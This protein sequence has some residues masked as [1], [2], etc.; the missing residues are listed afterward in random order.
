[1][2]H[3]KSPTPL[4]AEAR[5]RSAFTLVELLVVIAAIGVL[6]VLTTLGAR[7]LTQGTRLA[8]ATNQVVNA[9]GNARAAAIRDGVVTGLMFRPAWFPATPQI[10]QRV[11]IVTIRSTG[12]REFFESPIP[13]GPAF[14]EAF[15]PVPE[16]PI[17]PLP[18]GIKVAGPMFDPPGNIG[19]VAA[20]LVW[21]TQMEA[22]LAASCAEVTNFNRTV[23]VLFA[24]DGQFLTRPPKSSA[25]ESKSF[26]DWY[27]NG[28]QDVNQ[29]PSPPPQTPLLLGVC[30]SGNFEWF[31]LQDGL[32]DECNL[33]FV[34]YL[35]VYDDRA[36]REAKTTDWGVLNNML[37]ELTG[38][39]GYIA[40]FGDRISFN[41]FSGL[42]ER[43]GR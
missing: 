15:R 11:E 5:R 41:R 19:G 6:A 31:W 38:P 18:E 4:A 25:N 1:M 9:L 22:P 7:R 40:Q 36:A 20:E 28:R 3:E 10:P 32:D 21:A 23:A 16:I 8:S 42:P 17:I 37:V 2:L 33:M 26:V 29:Q 13:V 12:I 35:S 14:A 24:P 27:P 30:N 43:K 34:P 39:G